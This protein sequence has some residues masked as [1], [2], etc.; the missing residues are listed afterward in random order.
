MTLHTELNS[1]TTLLGSTRNFYGAMDFF[2]VSTYFS[3]YSP[4]LQHLYG[5]TIVRPLKNL[6]VDLGY[7]YMATATKL[8][9]LNMTLGHNI[10]LSASY[11][12]MKDVSISAGYSYMTIPI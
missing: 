6:S 11:Q 2:Y 4:G 7:H 1:F 5:G 10:E 8:S 9:G 3:T 12:L